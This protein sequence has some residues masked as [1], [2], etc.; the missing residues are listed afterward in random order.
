MNGNNESTQEQT[1]KELIDEI[2][3]IRLELENIST[4][5][6]NIVNELD[7]IH[8]N[9]SFFVFLFWLKI[10]FWVFIIFASISSGYNI[11]QEFMQI[12]Q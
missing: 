5:N 8:G 6:A 12:L 4:Q 3:K 9:T 7:E 10:F 1:S 2:K 11:I